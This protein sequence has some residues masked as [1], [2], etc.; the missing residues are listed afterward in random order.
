MHKQMIIIQYNITQG[1]E[2]DYPL[3]RTSGYKTTHCYVSFENN[4]EWH[5]DKYCYVVERNIPMVDKNK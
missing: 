4:Q 1:K 5:L 2:Y 3:I